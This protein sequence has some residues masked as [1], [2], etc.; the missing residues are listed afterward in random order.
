MELVLYELV[1]VLFISCTHVH[2]GYTFLQMASHYSANLQAEVNWPESWRVVEGETMQAREDK[3]RR[4][5]WKHP[6]SNDRCCFLL[7]WSHPTVCAWTGIHF[8]Q[9]HFTWST[10]L[11]AQQ[12]IDS[13]RHH[14]D[15]SFDL[16]GQ[17]HHS[18]VGLCFQFSTWRSLSAVLETSKSSLNIHIPALN[19]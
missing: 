12:I 10:M 7:A 11:A 14:S 9:A 2:V 8:L 15:N 3:N 4:L 16:I 17:M 13:S 1:P 19:T 18:L 6:D 5:M